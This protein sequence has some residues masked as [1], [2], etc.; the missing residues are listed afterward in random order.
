M[1]SLDA[2]HTSVLVLPISAYKYQSSYL[3][4]RPHRCL[5]CFHDFFYSVLDM[6]RFHKFTIG[7][8]W[9]SD[10]GSADEKKHYENL[11]KYSPLHNVKVPLGDGIQVVKILWLYKILLLMQKVTFIFKIVNGMSNENLM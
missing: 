7:Y 8:C 1:E 2:T 4:V 6:L 10:Y 3:I 5:I 11:I 9:V